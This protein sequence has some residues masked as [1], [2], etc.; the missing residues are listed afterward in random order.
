M[1]SANK[2]QRSAVDLVIQSGWIVRLCISVDVSKNDD[3]GATSASSLKH[4]LKLFA[5]PNTTISEIKTMVQRQVGISEK[6][7]L[8]AMSAR[9]LLT[10]SFG[11][12]LQRIYGK[13]DTKLCRRFFLRLKQ[14][15]LDPR[16][17][18]LLNVV[19]LDDWKERDTVVA[20]A[21]FD[22]QLLWNVDKECPR[23]HKLDRLAK[24]PI[25]NCEEG[26]DN[27]KYECM[28]CH[29]TGYYLESTDRTYHACRYWGDCFRYCVCGPCRK[30][31]KSKAST[32]NKSI[33]ELLE[34]LACALGFRGARF[35]VRGFF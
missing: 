6:E 25:G 13:V 35:S 7:Q 27:S 4:Q 26:S 18:S 3:N 11:V 20:K 9:P 1:S 2:L 19:G 21:K 5:F 8:L 32:R 17:E 12:N 31:E 16:L 24:Q 28:I 15:P 10:G 34:Y 23:G 22:G 14:L 30:G 33:H 29:S